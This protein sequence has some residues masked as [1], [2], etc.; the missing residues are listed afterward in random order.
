MYKISFFVPEDALNYVKEAMFKMGAGKIGNYDCCSFEILGMG[1]FRAL[2]NA[3][4]YIGRIGEL[5]KVKEYKV[6]MICEDTVIKEVIRAMKKSHPY[7][8]PAYDVTKVEDF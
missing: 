8:T 2:S 3:N 4:P 5:E 6:E 1:Q 7:E